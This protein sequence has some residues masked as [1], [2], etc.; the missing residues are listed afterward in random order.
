MN[1][2]NVGVAEAAKPRPL[3]AAS[4]EAPGTVAPQTRVPPQTPPTPQTTLT[5]HT[6]VTPETSNAFVMHNKGSVS[7]L[8]SSRVTRAPFIHTT[9]RLLT[10]APTP[11]SPSLTPTPPY[12]RHWLPRIAFVP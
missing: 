12:L 4:W 1:A 8:N 11:C 5:P 7:V 10:L 3:T 2:G 6:T 9:P